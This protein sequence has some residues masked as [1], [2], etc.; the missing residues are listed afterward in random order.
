MSFDD[1]TSAARVS[2]DFQHDCYWQDTDWGKWQI[3]PARIHRFPWNLGC[4]KWSDFVLSLSCLP[5]KRDTIRD[6][7]KRRKWQWLSRVLTTRLSFLLS[8][9]TDRNNGSLSWWWRLKS[10]LFCLLGLFND[11]AAE[12]RKTTTSFLNS[13]SIDI[14]G[15]SVQAII[16]RNLFG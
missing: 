2:Q 16:F 1:L 11:D 6:K 14:L 13:S 12:T 9:E 8:N 15:H 3:S 7:V 10:Y 5:R 4:G